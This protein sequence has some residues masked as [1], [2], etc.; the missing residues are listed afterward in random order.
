MAR[1]L[2]LGDLRT[3]IRDR[4]EWRGD[5]ITDTQLDAWI[6]DACFKFY[7]L[8]SEVDPWR[9]LERTDITISSGT[10]EYALPTDFY[11]L[12]GVA[13][14]DATA[15]GYSLLESFSWEERY[16]DMY[17]AEKAST[18]YMIHGSTGA[19]HTQEG[20]YVIEFQPE[21]DWS[22]TVRVE[23]VPQFD[24]LVGDSDDFDTINGLGEEWIVCDVAIKACAKEETDPAVYAAQKTEAEKLLV[25]TG[26]QDATSPRPS[27]TAE[28]LRDLQLAIRNRGTWSRS[29]VP[30][31]KL[32]EFINGSIAALRDLVC[33]TD[34]SHFVEYDEI[35]VASG[36]RSYDLVSDFYKCVGVD[37]VDAAASD[38]YA[39]MKQFS[40]EE[41]YD[42]TYAV[43]QSNTRYHIRGNKI[44]FHPTPDWTNMV[45]VE[46]I[47]KYTALVNPTDTFDTF[48]HWHEYIVLDA[49]IK[50]T[51]S[52]D[53]D[54]AAYMAQK[55]EAEKRIASLAIVDI[56]DQKRT[57]TAGTLENLQLAIRNRGNWLR[58]DM[59]DSQLTEWINSSISGLRNV[60]IQ[61]DPTY[62]VTYEDIAV[63]SGD[64][65]YALPSDFLKA[66]GVDVYDAAID[67]GYQA[68]NH[69]NWEERYDVATSSK[70]E[71]RYHLRGGN[72]YLH[73]TPTW[74]GTVRLEYI[75]TFAGLTNPT[76]TVS[77]YDN[78]QE[79]VVLDCA[80]KCSALKGTDPQVY[81][82]QQQ[83]VEERIKAIAV[84]NA[85]DQTTPSTDG[86][87]G[88][89]RLA[90]R[91]R[92]GWAKDK[93]NDSQLT[94]WINGSLA[95][96][97]DLVA[98]TDPSHFVEYED[99]T[100]A[101]GTRAYDLPADFYKCVGV[102]MHDAG[103]SDGYA[104][105]KQFNWT[106][107][108]DDTYAVTKANTRYHIRGNQIHLH[109]TPDY[110]D[111]VRLEYIPKYTA[112]VSP[113]D[114]FETFN[115][116]HEWLMLDVCMKA[117]AFK[118]TDPQIYA[119]Q[120][121]KAEER[122][123]T[124][125]IVDIHEQ[126]TSSTSGTLEDL[127]VA[128]RNRGGWRRTDVTDSQL[129]ESI[130][131]SIAELRDL[132]AKSDPS[133]FVEFEDIS[134]VSGTR[135][136]SLPA[137]FYK[138]VGADAYDAS[139]T[140]GYATMKQFNWTERYDDT[141]TGTKANTRY[142]IRGD[143][144]HFHPTPTW[145][146]VV[147]LEYIPT[148]TALVDPTD[149]FDTFNHWQEHIVLNTCV[150]TS[151]SLGKD[152][153]A[154]VALKSEAENRIANF[155]VQDIHEQKRTSA[156]D[157]LENIQLAVRNRGG[158]LR[159]DIV[160]S[161]LTEWVNGSMGALVDVMSLND[162]SHFLS[163]HY[164]TMTGG[165]EFALPSDFY[166]AIGM[167]VNYDSSSDYQDGYYSIEECTWQEFSRFLKT[168]ADAT[169]AV[170]DRRFTIRGDYIYITPNPYGS[171]QARLEYIASPELLVNP[172][173]TV[174]FPNRW[175]E[176]LVLDVA[177]KAAAFMKTD[178]QVF[179]AQQQRCEERIKAFAE[180]N[181][182]KP[183]TWNGSI[184]T[185]GGMRKAIR[186][187]G[188]WSVDQITNDLITSMINTSMLNLHDFIT[189]HD[190]SY[191]YKESIISVSSGDREYSLPRDFYKLLGVAVYD[192][193]LADEYQALSSFNWNERYDVSYV[194]DENST[195]YALQGARSLW[196]QPTPT[197][198]GTIKLDYVSKPQLVTDGYQT[199]SDSAAFFGDTPTS[200]P[201]YSHHLDD[202]IYGQHF[203]FYGWILADV[204]GKL[205]TTMKQ[206]PSA[207]VMEK[208]EVEE[209]FV[210]YLNKRDISKQLTA[211]TSETLRN[212]QFAVRNR[213]DWARDDFNDA[214]LTEWI[215]S[216]IAA[217]YD[218][219]I[220][221][222]DSHFINYGDISIVSG[223]KG[224][225]LPSD[226]Y[227]IKGVA[228]RDSSNPDGYAIIERY[229]Y[230][231]RYDHSYVTNNWNTRYIVLGQNIEFH[232][233]PNW[234]DTVRLEYIPL[235]TAMDDPADTF[236]FVN[237]W[238]E[239]VI[240]SAAVK[241]CALKKE[242]PSAYMMQLRE[243][244]KRITRSAE[245]DVGKPKTVVDVYRGS[246]HRWW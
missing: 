3:L 52:V 27:S 133:H 29:D 141:Y 146:A 173:D 164:F 32:T 49:C 170:T 92:G 54:P 12:S 11:R 104:T 220:M 14:S 167:S 125:G 183:T 85:I 208:K 75:P 210:R 240:L 212:L 36:T 143:E 172:S 202:G 89:L 161:Q 70:L 137:G 214:Q 86:T 22:G 94:A 235:P 33:K 56:H 114:T 113:T 162:D 118:G 154:F 140:D 17:V 68:I 203:F 101:S 119:A 169:K 51:I 233:I 232:P 66:V 48:N 96:L 76:D 23:Y 57:S 187:R 42:D 67:D 93:I 157:T 225:S 64:R 230:D 188:G 122:I 61:I 155:A 129:T 126:K 197:W 116:W 124:F 246:K 216:S 73:P 79:W 58:T 177:Q 159:T 243:V 43:S 234:S 194:S 180:R 209:S 160:D 223:T 6:N 8:M 53:K 224:Y 199:L 222:D 41:R 102:D 156:V 77:L 103:Y 221:H 110:V 39:L 145:T 107:R 55:V 165:A 117:S 121:Q 59:T 99:I 40:W 200:D 128:I 237:H 21:P 100:T 195:R 44:H 207:F 65:E 1:R 98:K 144:I 244:E 15:D 215:E 242:D 112:L 168:S 5:Y 30:D 81:M 206:D 24:D 87:L 231:E 28:T 45:R 18:R 19:T 105:M 241:A 158:W 138:C 176:W 153:A 9:Y 120:L 16:D 152:P 179:M 80:M 83:K 147:R 47:P 227:K 201:N 97:R 78:W 60:L 62:F 239:Y 31:A 193:A 84:Q 4:G 106:E 127:Q 192:A 150:K 130:N 196:L 74:T 136:Y 46:Y 163:F 71:T 174:S 135:S 69:F 34:P 186:G 204:C 2:A 148:Y 10:K 189:I 123:S 211:P 236:R 26:V 115:H 213:G 218:L 91:A 20:N 205:S 142:H 72:L 7:S 166:K 139:Y 191:F 111:V 181:R 50:T 178:P 37:V 38:G 182:T 219:V 108:Y 134:V 132:V 95:A 35:P 245:Q 25:K 229:N 151:V 175:I 184:E 88:N 63:S 198:S 238:Q 149:T 171:L 13:L 109:P 226:F 190:P 228:V 217:F 82:A 131:S 90:V 185:V